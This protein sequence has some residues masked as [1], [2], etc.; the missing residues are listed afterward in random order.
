MPNLRW[1]KLNQTGLEALPD[2]LSHLMKLVN[3][4]EFFY[5]TELKLDTFVYE[6]V[7]FQK[8]LNCRRTRHEERCVQNVHAFAR[9]I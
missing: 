8:I 3:I 9:N 5:F 1:L 6:L 2:E 4:S 7:V